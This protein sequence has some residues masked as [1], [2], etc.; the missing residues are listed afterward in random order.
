MASESTKQSS[1]D[2]LRRRTSR[3]SLGLSCLLVSALLF[4][5]GILLDGLLVRLPGLKTNAS[6]PAEAVGALHIHTKASD[7]SGTVAQVVAA[8]R[9]AQLSFIAIT[10]HNVSMSETDLN[11]DPSDLPIIPGEELTTESGHFVTLGIPPNWQRPHSA[12]ADALLSAAHAAGGFNIVAHPYWSKVPWTDWNTDRFDALE[13]W[14]GV[15]TLERNQSSSILLSIVLGGIN[16]RL[17]ISRLERTPEQNFAKWDQLLARRPVVGLCG[18]D[19]HALLRLGPGGI[20][21]W[22]Y[23]P[24]KWVFESV[25]Q[26]VLVRSNRG[27][28]QTTTASALEIL[29]ALRNGHA[30]CALDGLRPANGF[31]QRVVS[32][33]SSGGPGDFVRWSDGSTISVQVPAGGD[34][35]IIEIFRDGREIYQRHASSFS[36]P[37]PGPG[38]YRTEVFLPQPGWTAWGRWT[39]WIFSNPTYVGQANG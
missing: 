13:V 1:A 17:A 10:D 4:I 3:S 12:N 26:H 15:E 20:L 11:E 27:T 23:P 6:S 2:K 28:G 8:A 34:K 29:D 7:G 22:R 16:H 18:T 21:R 35:P 9:E 31:I 32:G 25:R 5:L 37:L 39:L 33:A 14:N 38:C 24:Y 19:A 36:E 30:F